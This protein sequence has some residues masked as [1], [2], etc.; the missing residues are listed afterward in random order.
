MR[1]GYLIPEFPGQTHAFFWRERQA[2]KELGVET[3]VISTFRPP[4]EIVSHNW[5]K[6]A[7]NEVV[8]LVP[9][10][11]K[12]ALNILMIMLEAGFSAWLNC[13]QKVI[14]ADDVSFKQRLRLI[15]LLPVA[16][17]LVWLSKVQ[18][19]SHI[20]VHSCGNSADIA[21]FASLL[22]KISYSLT[23]HGPGFDTYGPNQSQ[24]W[25]HAS[26]GTLVSDLLL[27]ESRAR[28]GSALPK[29]VSVV[30]M[31]VDLE[32]LARDQPYVP[33]QKKQPCQIFT[34]GRL[35]PIKGHD[36]LIEAVAI[37]V[38]QG[39]DI[40]LRIAGEDELGGKGYRLHLESILQEK[41]M[42][43][44]VQLLGAVSEKTIRQQL[45]EA[46]VFALSSLNEGT[47]VAI[48]EAMAMELPV[49]ATAVG[50][51]PKLIADGVDGILVEPK[52][53]E[54][55]ASA[56]AKVL[57]DSQLAL[58]LGKAARQTIAERYH[59]RRSAEVLAEFLQ[60]K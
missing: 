47:S 41:R 59:H 2:L 32:M 40:Y 15:A 23:Q 18:G 24:K 37:L 57:M 19:W 30:P 52:K 1:I 12:D 9:P 55:M 33:W 50:G 42:T 17:K 3:D 27:Q 48:M 35:N 25:Q 20:H 5:A 60:G 8:Y 34:I 28:L 10:S 53:S 7:Q 31:G 29:R 51:T 11:F 14:Q 39:F 21:L 43:D 22:S 38:N 54:E 49:V 13:L 16:A 56:I 44:R 45:Q 58:N 4:Q 26:F 46:H 36:D 6:Q